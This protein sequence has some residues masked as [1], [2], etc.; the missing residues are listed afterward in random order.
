MSVAY[1][2]EME[3]EGRLACFARP[4]SGSCGISYIAPPHSVVYGIFSSIARLQTTHIEPREVEICRPIQ[5]LRLVRNTRH[6]EV[7][8]D[9]YGQFRR[10]ALVNVCWVL[11]GECIPSPNRNHPEFQSNPHYLQGL[12]NRRLKRGFRKHFIYL[13]EMQF[14]PSYWGPVRY[15]ETGKRVNL[16]IEEIN[17]VDIL[18]M[19]YLSYGNSGKLFYKFGPARITKGIMQYA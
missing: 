6:A 7:T 2:V 19:Q 17:E 5:M 9:K 18:A 16:P 4:D 15:D 11:R 14:V 13:G 10:T 8:G 3:I 12:F 1:T